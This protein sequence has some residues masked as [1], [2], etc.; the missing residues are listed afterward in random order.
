MRPTVLRP[1]LVVD[2]NPDDRFFTRRALL[3]AR[4]ENPLVELDNGEAAIAYLKTLCGPVPCV[5]FI[6]INMP[7]VGGFDVL[8]Y[9]K[10][11]GS[12]RDMKTFILSG[13]DDPHDYRRAVELGADSYL[14][15]SVNSEA[16]SQALS[17]VECI[18]TQP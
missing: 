4:M 7:M 14:L 3:A 5:A 11:E 13:S 2:D 17:R 15:K 16:I 18:V 1:V 6:D 10:N 12:L 8:A 9:A